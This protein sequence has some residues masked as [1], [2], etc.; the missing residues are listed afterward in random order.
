MTAA[1]TVVAMNANVN[2]SSPRTV[3][4]RVP[5]QPQPIPIRCTE[6]F[7]RPIYRS[8][9]RRENRA[10]SSRRFDPNPTQ[11]QQQCKLRAVYR[12]FTPDEGPLDR[13]DFHFN[14][15]FESHD[16]EADMVMRLSDDE[17]DFAYP[18]RLDNMMPNGG[19]GNGSGNGNSK[20]KRIREPI[21]EPICQ[22]PKPRPRSK[23]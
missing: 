5:P 14:M 15:Y 18:R 17:K 3:A 16:I 6:T 19:K 9:K 13:C 23:R 20:G 12:I 8:R 22:V 11:K 4:I 2:V 7:T 1:A 10:A 21:R